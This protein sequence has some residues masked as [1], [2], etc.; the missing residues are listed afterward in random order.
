MDNTKRTRTSP[1]VNLK[2][3][4]LCPDEFTTRDFADRAGCSLI[5]A[6]KFLLRFLSLGK[7]KELPIPNAWRKVTEEET[8]PT[9]R[10]LLEEEVAIINGAMEL[11]QKL[12]EE[13]R[14]LKS[15][16]EHWAE[17]AKT[18]KVYHNGR[19]SE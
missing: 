9:G 2:A 3:F 13:N 11:I 19:E 15:Q 7:V 8:K 16:V 1:K 18:A 10:A 6:R 5:P 17:M 12:I 4:E 14:W